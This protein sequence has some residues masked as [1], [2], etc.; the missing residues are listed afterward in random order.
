MCF[1]FLALLAGSQFSWQSEW[2]PNHWTAREFRVCGGELV[3]RVVR[4]ELTSWYL[5]RPECRREQ[6]EWLARGKALQTEQ[7]AGAD[8]AVGASLVR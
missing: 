7:A 2:S 1:V 5:G 8:L 4:E 6:A 3:G